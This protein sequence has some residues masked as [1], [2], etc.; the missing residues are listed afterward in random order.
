MAHLAG[1]E[2]AIPQFGLQLSILRSVQTR[3]ESSLFD[4]RQFARLDAHHHINAALTLV[5]DDVSSC[6]DQF[7]PQM[8]G[9]VGIAND[10]E[11][12]TFLHAARQDIIGPALVPRTKSFT[13]GSEGEV[14]R[15]NY[16]EPVK[17]IA[18]IDQQRIAVLGTTGRLSVWNYLSRDL[19]AVENPIGKLVKAIASDSDGRMYYVAPGGSIGVVTF[20]GAPVHRVINLP[21]LDI[22]EISCFEANTIAFVTTPNRTG[23]LNLITGTVTN[24]ELPDAGRIA[25]LAT[26]SID[27][28]AFGT[29]TGDVH[30]WHAPSR[31]LTTIHATA[32]E[33]T[34]R[35]PKCVRCLVFLNHSRLITGIPGEWSSFFLGSTGF[36][37]WDVRTGALI[38]EVKNTTFGTNALAVDSDQIVFA[39]SDLYV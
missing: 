30:I 38:K 14:S 4:F 24:I 35:G 15:L 5:A 11:V 28:I 19:S 18:R 29:S 32:S 26:N 13:S 25:C 39:A 34:F 22:H 21:V 7:L 6:P 33:E 12:T 37:I 36:R 10:P 23:V 2:A 16:G 27:R 20:S 31:V 8:L 17:M 1:P 3:F 9:R